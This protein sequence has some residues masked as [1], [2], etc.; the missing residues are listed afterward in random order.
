[1]LYLFREMYVRFITTQ[2]M[3]TSVFCWHRHEKGA[4]K[5]SIRDLPRN[6]GTHVNMNREQN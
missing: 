4:D 6:W 3:P 1:M 5:P 2:I